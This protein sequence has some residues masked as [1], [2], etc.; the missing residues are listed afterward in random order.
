M[1]DYVV[2]FAKSA[3]RDLE[4]LD[5]VTVQRV[6]S[7]IEALTKQPRP[8]GCQKLR[9]SKNLWRIRV[10]DY[11][12]VYSIFDDRRLVDVAAV[13]HRREAYD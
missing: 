12:V 7:K 6:F 8:P 13:R 5:A 10:G 2:V 3:W 11:R 4:S 9:G 1:A